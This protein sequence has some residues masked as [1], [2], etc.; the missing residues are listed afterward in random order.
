VFKPDRS[1]HAAPAERPATMVSMNLRD[2]PASKAYAELARQAGVA[3][4]FTPKPLDA[5]PEGEPR[6]T[7]RVIQ[8]PFWAAVDQLNRQSGLVVQDVARQPAP[9]VTFRRPEKP[10]TFG[11][12]QT[13]VAGAFHATLLDRTAFT[14]PPPAKHAR[15]GR[16]ELGVQLHAEPKLRPLFWHSMQVEELTDAAGRHIPYVV[17]LNASAPRMVP[18]YAGPAYM[19][20]R[21]DGPVDALHVGRFTVTGK[22]MAAPRSEV[23]EV[24]GLHSPFPAPATPAGSRSTRRSSPTIAGACSASPSRAPP[25]TAPRG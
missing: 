10:G 25:T 9:L 1:A 5:F 4:A 11:E 16:R 17:L 15:P 18:F 21:V 22:V 13:F 7:V 24:T 8:E 23:A 3:F 6:L 2:A 20:L 19:A 14:A 12:L